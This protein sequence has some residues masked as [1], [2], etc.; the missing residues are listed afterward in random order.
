MSEGKIPIDELRGL[1]KKLLGTI[2][3]KKEEASEH[4]KDRH[5]DREIHLLDRMRG[6]EIREITT[7]QNLAI[8][9]LQLDF[10]ET[11]RLGEVARILALDAAAVSS[12]AAAAV[13]RLTLLK[14][15]LEIAELRMKAQTKELV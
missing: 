8:G 1:M 6:I 15:E 11:Q 7:S 10:I 9:E 2:Q 4:D 3:A 13:N 14:T 5:E 12:K